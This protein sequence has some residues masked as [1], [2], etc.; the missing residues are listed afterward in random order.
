NLI[1]QALGTAD[2]ASPHGYGIRVLVRT[3]PVVT[4]GVG[5]VALQGA[6]GTA[7]FTEP[8]QAYLRYDGLLGPD[9]TGMPRRWELSAPA[10]V[11][12][13]AFD[14]L[15][16]APVPFPHGTVELSMA[17]D[18]LVVE[19]TMAVAAV[20]RDGVGEVMDD[21]DLAWSS[22]DP[23]VATVDGAGMVTGMGPGT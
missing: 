13:F 9:S 6:D 3:P 8:D 10:G 23:T 22:S 19:S 15:G 16:S 7:E 5:S 4:G 17:G 1:D 21:P 14:L 11:T 2:G 20:V 12:S 18:T